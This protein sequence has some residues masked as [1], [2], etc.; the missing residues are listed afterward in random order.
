MQVFT[1][2]FYPL[3]LHS[4]LTVTSR[5]PQRNQLVC[6]RAYELY[7]VVRADALRR[8]FALGADFMAQRERLTLSC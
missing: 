1:V 6:T 2:P 3:G 7:R 4:S 8:V 5:S